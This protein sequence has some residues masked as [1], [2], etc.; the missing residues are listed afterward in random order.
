MKLL[1]ILGDILGSL[2]K[3]VD[4]QGVYKPGHRGKP[5][6]RKLSDAEVRDIRIR[7]H[8]K[9]ESIDMIHAKY[10][11]V[12]RKTIEDIVKYKVRLSPGCEI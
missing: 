4:P 11:D 9:G 8:R 5:G 12:V 3:N 6:P 7:F 2:N 10:P 1:E